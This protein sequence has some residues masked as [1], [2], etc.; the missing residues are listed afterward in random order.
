MKDS[1][2]DDTVIDRLQGALDGET[3]PKAA[4]DYA[5]HLLNRLSQPVRVSILGAPRSGKSEL[6]N[7]FVGRRL[8]PKD[9]ALPTTEFV[10]AA[11]EA[12]TVTGADGTV[13]R[14]DK[15]DLEALAD[16]SAAFLKLELP[17][18]ILKRI[19]LLEVVTNGAHEEIES[20]I[21]WAVRRTDIALWCSQAFDAS[22]QSVWSRVP[23]S[24]KDHAF[25]V[26]TK[27][28]VLSAE[29]LLSTR[30]AE[31]ESIVAEEF[32]S[33][34]AV[35]TLQ[36]VEAKSG[37]DVDEAM[38]H[39][40]GGGALTS[41]ILRHAERG[42]RAD[43][44]SAHMFL[45]R[46]EVKGA[47]AGVAARTS[48]SANQQ[49]TPEAPPM[50]APPSPPPVAETPEPIPVV[51]AAK[52]EPAPEA[53]M[54]TVETAEPEPAP[55]ADAPE[56]APVSEATEPA[57]VPEDES[58]AETATPPSVD[59]PALPKV[60]NVDLFLESVK[61]LKRRGE[62]LTKTA[63]E[64]GEGQVKPLVEQCVDAVEHL[65]DLFSQD[66]TGC[67]ATDAFIDELAEASDMMVLMQVEDGDAPA[68]DA[69]TL[70]LQLRRDMEMQ[71]AA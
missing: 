53:P 41:E 8:I 24:L 26:L 47:P 70:L 59:L 55:M 65:T 30:V 5:L 31:L 45:A 29:K 17:V 1:A 28:D 62:A 6:V 35:A 57:P 18:D 12:M 48:A 25:L 56:P 2:S 14:F 33:L 51:E 10:W 71:L 67:A 15:I 64:M 20:A 36:A 60:E 68:A 13:N 34:F 63:G 50:A 22:E 4:R 54:P 44:D 40:S 43:F 3:M 27:A 61:Y 66:E 16:G 38:F 42:R 11:E 49:A 9:A 21:D 7:M 39:A 52:P 69:V 37:A 23:D 19:N 46:Y 58:T 32:H